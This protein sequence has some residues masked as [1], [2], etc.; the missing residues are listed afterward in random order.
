MCR[1]GCASGVLP[2]LISRV[3]MTNL[4]SSPSCRL[5]SCESMSPKKRRS[6]SWFQEEWESM[7]VSTQPR[8]PT[9]LTSSLTVCSQHPPH[10]SP[11]SLLHPGRNTCVGKREEEGEGPGPLDSPRLVYQ[12]GAG[13]CCLRPRQCRFLQG[14][15][16]HDLFLIATVINVNYRII[17]NHR[18]DVI[19]APLARTAVAFCSGFP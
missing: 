15:F 17:A 14:C 6:S 2:G 19:P 10:R 11:W 12:R 3:L 7:P 5:C 1:L 4:L 9:R 13:P 8:L 16:H 18:E